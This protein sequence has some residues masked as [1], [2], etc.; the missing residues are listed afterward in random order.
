MPPTL[1]L[2]QQE[3]QPQSTSEEGCPRQCWQ[4]CQGHL[5]KLWSN[6]LSRHKGGCMYVPDSRVLRERASGWVVQACATVP[7]GASGGLLERAEHPHQVHL[8]QGSMQGG[9][10]EVSRLEGAAAICHAA[11]R[12]GAAG[13]ASGGCRN[14]L[15][16]EQGTP[17]FG[18]EAPKQDR[19]THVGSSLMTHLEQM[20]ITATCTGLS[21]Y[22]TSQAFPFWRGEDLPVVGGLLKRFSPE[23]KVPA[24][25]NRAGNGGRAAP[26]RQT[27]IPCGL[28]GTGCLSALS[29]SGLVQPAP[30]VEE[31]ARMFGAEQDAQMDEAE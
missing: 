4:R 29:T 13:P 20:L 2:M 5:I 31:D 6:L 16:T 25:I 11:Q 7:Q 12:G 27:S 10:R 24:A 26:F 21:F 15:G 28:H 8:Q 18:A 17:L 22:G 19:C 9:G 1:L 14:Q 30:E 3:G 23:S